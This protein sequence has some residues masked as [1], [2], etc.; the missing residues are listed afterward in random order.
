MFKAIVAANAGKASLHPLVLHL[1]TDAS[2]AALQ[3]T[4]A[5]AG[6]P[7]RRGLDDGR[8]ELTF[9]WVGEAPSVSLQC[10][11]ADHSGMPVPMQQMG[12][13][14]VWALAV[15]AEGDELVSYRFVIDDPFQAAGTLDDN[16]WQRVMLQAQLRSFADP[17][18]PR[19][20]APLAV[21]F[22]L[23]PPA[24]QW[25]S[26]LA[27]R[28]APESPWF[29]LQDTF[30]APT[31]TLDRFDLTS[32]ALG[33][34]RTITVYQPRSDSV[35][36]ADRPLVVLLDG[37]S[38]IEIAGVPRALDAAI[39]SGEIIAPVVAFVHEAH[40]SGGLADRVRELSCNPHHA[41]M[42]ATE[43]LPAL[44][45]RYACAAAPE[46]TVLGG[47]SLGGLASMYTALEHP[48]SIGNVLSVSGSFWYGTERDGT[49]EWLTRR[50]TAAPASGLRVYQQI[51]RLEDGA[52]SLSPGVSHLDANRHF[53]E[54]AAAQ[55]CE[56]TY[57]EMGTAHDIVAFRV[58]LLRGLRALIPRR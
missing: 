39:A 6:G 52:L 45:A 22:G 56:V 42:L 7:L 41:A 1:T 50:L 29:D 57:D 34:T 26:V 58:A 23:N 30:D 33:D 43:L 20:I 35:A 49:P 12:D 32:T 48:D 47:A 5:A 4:L 55:G 27:L 46:H 36:A 16:G 17:N 51:G 8:V 13:A 2:L 21:L 31:G 24:D 11:L 10:G 44:R 54:V 37:R 3:Q 14:P 38:W 53:H 15:V 9:V 18:N 19:R 40:G 25:E 28:D